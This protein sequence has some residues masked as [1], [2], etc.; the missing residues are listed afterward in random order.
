MPVASMLTDFALSHQHL[1]TVRASSESSL[2][3]LAP[4]V[5][6][7]VLA[8]T[9]ARLGARL[10]RRSSGDHVRY[11]DVLRLHEWCEKYRTVY[12]SKSTIQNY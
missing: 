6:I 10:L 7:T 12:R 2:F 1:L 8:F 5:P 9:F 11:E 3:R 4:I